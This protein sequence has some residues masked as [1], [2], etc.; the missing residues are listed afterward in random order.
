MLR[1]ATGRLGTKRSW[2]GAPARQRGILDSA[3]PRSSKGGMPDISVAA[4]VH[5]S[6]DGYLATPTGPPRG[7]FGVASVNY[8]SVPKDARGIREGS[9][10]IVASYGGRDRSLRTH[11]ARL[12]SALD[13]LAITHDFEDY[14]QAGHSFLNQQPKVPAPALALGPAA[15]RVRA[16]T[17]SCRRRMGRIFAFFAEHLRGQ[18]GMAPTS[19]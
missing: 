9:C 19:T 18:P 15:V 1:E 2:A 8:G 10:P 12:R 6:L 3:R 7:G 11:A 5:E 13:D 14:P 4:T 16:S 17:G